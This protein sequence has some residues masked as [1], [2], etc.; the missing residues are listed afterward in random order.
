MLNKCTQALTY[1]ILTSKVAD[2]N[3]RYGEVCDTVILHV[4]SRFEQAGPKDHHNIYKMGENSVG[5]L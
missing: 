5:S 2:S 3:R 4:D 1:L